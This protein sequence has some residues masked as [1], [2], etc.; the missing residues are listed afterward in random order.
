MN[1]TDCPLCDAGRY[2]NSVSLVNPV[3][4][5]ARTPVHLGC[6]VKTFNIYTA[7]AVCLDCL[8]GLMCNEMNMPDP[9][10]CKEGHYCP[11]A[12]PPQPCPAGTFNNGTGLKADIEFQSCSVG[13]YCKGNGNIL[14]TGMAILACW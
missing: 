1:Y 9:K 5:R 11:A 4:L 14:P 7:Q 6:Q 13:K 8:A 12:T 10:P 3:G 2:S